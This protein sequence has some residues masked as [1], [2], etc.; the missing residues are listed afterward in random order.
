MAGCDGAGD[1]GASST[2]RGGGVPSG[3]D[4]GPPARRKRRPGRPSFAA[5]IAEVQTR[6]LILRHARVLF[7]QRGYADVSVGE[8]AEAVGV[9]KPTLYYHFHDKEGLYAAVL[10]DVMHEVGGYLRAVV[11]RPISLRERLV[12]LAYGYFL[13]ADATMEPML[14]D[15]SELIGRERAEQV[16]AAYQTEMIDPIAALFSEGIARGELS[17][18][19]PRWL[20]RAFTGLLDAF[21]E[22]G[23]HLARTDAEHRISSERLVSLFLGGA[24]SAEAF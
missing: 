2:A 12:E 24:Q 18:R 9:S 21:T 4:G 20:V 5:P 22:S 6:S 14:R 17:G 1:P 23:G 10:I 16:L 11:H 13:H 7:M 15:T 3:G 19:D 8:V